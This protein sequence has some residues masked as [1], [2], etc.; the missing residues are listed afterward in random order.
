MATLDALHGHSAW[1]PI[2]RDTARFHGAT[3]FQSAHLTREIGDI[4]RTILQREVCAS[5]GALKIEVHRLDA[6]DFIALHTDEGVC[7]LRIVTFLGHDWKPSDGGF[8]VF[9]DRGNVRKTICISPI[10]NTAV[11]FLTGR[12]TEHGVS[13]VSSGSRYSIVGRLPVR[14]RN[15]PSQS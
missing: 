6:G 12:A 10:H 15:G 3:G 8:L 5:D 7:E 2:V 1:K 4:S 13:E 11:A 9:P 14:F